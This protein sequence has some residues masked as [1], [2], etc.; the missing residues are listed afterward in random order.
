M[1]IPV[2]NCIGRVWLWPTCPP[3]VSEPD[4]KPGK[5]AGPWNLLATSTGALRTPGGWENVSA[6]FPELSSFAA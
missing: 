2:R 3:W 5:D 6:A 1:H 4:K